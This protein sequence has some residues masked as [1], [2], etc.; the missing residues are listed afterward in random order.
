MEK[1]IKVENM[2]VQ[3]PRGNFKIEEEFTSE[4]EANELDIMIISHWIKKMRY[5]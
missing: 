1:R 5:S 3:T 2:R 4:E